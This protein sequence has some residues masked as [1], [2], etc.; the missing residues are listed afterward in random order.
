MV[1]LYVYIIRKR[2]TYLYTYAR[3]RRKKFTNDDG[4]MD[5]ST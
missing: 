4:V 1:N 3:V 5:N 2:N